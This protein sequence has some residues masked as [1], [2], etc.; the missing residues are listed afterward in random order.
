MLGVHKSLEGSR[1]PQACGRK[2]PAAWRLRPLNAAV[3]RVERDQQAMHPNGLA[4]VPAINGNISIPVLTMHTIGDLYVP[5]SMEQIYAQ[6]VAAHGASDLLVQRAIRDVN[7]CSF[8]T[9][10][11]MGAFG[12]LAAWVEYGIKP[13]GDNLLDPAVVADPNFGCAFTSQDRLYPPPLSI[14][15][16]P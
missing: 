8:T 15:P 11:G 6:R 3:L 16:C 12:A 5:I 2:R 7:H 10:E 1:T 4:N 13:A 14:P 9:E